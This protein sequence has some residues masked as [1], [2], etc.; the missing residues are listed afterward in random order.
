MTRL[1]IV[2]LTISTFIVL[3]GGALLLPSK[4][5]ASSCSNTKCSS[6]STCD[7]GGGR[8][9]S[10]SATPFANICADGACSQ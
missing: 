4:A 3:V 5:R 1:R 2:L 6:S 9:C 7:F 8:T 10:L